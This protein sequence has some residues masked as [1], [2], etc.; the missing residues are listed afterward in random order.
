MFRILQRTPPLLVF[1]L[2]SLLAGAATLPLRDKIS[3]PRQDL[4]QLEGMGQA[5]LI[6]TLGGLRALAADFLWLRANFYWQIKNPGLTETTALAVTRL[7]PD[8]SYFWIETAR[9]VTFDMPVWRFGRQTPPKTIE[10]RIRREQAERG[11]EIL[12][13]GRKFL[14]EDSGLP[15]EMA[16][17]YWTVLQDPDTAQKYYREAYLMPDRRA[18]YARLRAVILMDLGRNEEAL[19]WLEKV[20][21]EMDRDR[22][23]AQYEM[24]VE[25]L[26]ELRGERPPGAPSRFDFL[27]QL[28][29]DAL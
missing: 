15:A 9:I 25:Y 12:Q 19:E 8:Y 27:P 16:R 29:V 24:M 17:I 4:T 14:P 21:P 26:Q 22:S 28:G 2:C 18:L 20:L 1:F 7:Q 23:P 5:V 13:E 3:P 11:L 10:Q 6:G